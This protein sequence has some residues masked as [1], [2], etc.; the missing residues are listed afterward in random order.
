MI[1]FINAMSA[2]SGGGQTYL[3]NLLNGFLSEKHNKIFIIAPKSLNIPKDKNNIIK[4][5]VSEIIVN[6]PFLR[7]FWEVLLLPFVLI[8]IRPDV[9]FYPGGVISGYV[10]KRCKTVVTF[11]NILPFDKRQC[12]KYGFGYMRLRNRILKSKMSSSMKKADLVIF[13]SRYAQ[14]VIEDIYMIGTSKSVV[15]YHGIDPYFKSR[16]PALSSNLPYISKDKYILYVSTIVVY[17]SQIEV[18]QAYAILK[19]RKKISQ[20]LI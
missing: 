18:V 12:Q 16:P 13:I 19:K 17:K 8:R 11:Q 14:H 20:K 6:N 7:L 10:P 1:I 5:Q 4:I 15:I 9:V 3:V 2:R